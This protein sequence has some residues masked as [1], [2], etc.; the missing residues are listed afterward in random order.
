MIGVVLWFDSRESKAVIWCEEK[1]EL[2]L[3]NAGQ[4]S[5]DADVQLEPGDLV[6][7]DVSQEGH[8]R[9]AH[10]PRPV[11]NAPVA[12]AQPGNRDCAPRYS[13]MEG[14]SGRDPG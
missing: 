8:R 2:A 5:S 11:R 3:F 14:R 6:R 7:F 1:G 13:L 9:R 12:G 4:G 10:N